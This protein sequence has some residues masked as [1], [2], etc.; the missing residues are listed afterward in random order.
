MEDVRPRHRLT[1]GG[2]GVEHEGRKL[3]SFGTRSLRDLLGSTSPDLADITQFELGSRLSY[4]M[5]RR[6]NG[7][8]AS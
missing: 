3:Y 8:S 7:R 5:N 1:V 6:A 4:V 2:A